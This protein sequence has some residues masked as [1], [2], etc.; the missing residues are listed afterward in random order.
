MRLSAAAV[1]PPEMARICPLPMVTSVGYQRPFRMSANWVHCLVPE[2]NW[3]EDFRPKLSTPACPPA[4]K[5]LPPLRQRQTTAEE[6]RRQGKVGERAGD[7]RVPEQRLAYVPPVADDLTVG[8][9]GGMDR[10]RGPGERRGPLSHRAGVGR[11]GKGLEADH[12]AHVPRHGRDAR[13]DVP[14]AA[15]GLTL[16]ASP[17]LDASSACR[18]RG[19]LHRAAPGEAR[20]AVAR[21]PPGRR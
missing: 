9:Q 12:D 11:G 15:L 20:A 21:R 4:T 14:P 2:L 19:Q 13:A 16:P 7:G 1:S 8:Q 10:H 6:I 3:Y 17:S 5:R 18:G